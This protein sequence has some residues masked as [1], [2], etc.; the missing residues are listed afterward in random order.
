MGRRGIFLEHASCEELREGFRKVFFDIQSHTVNHKKLSTLSTQDLNYELS[1]DQLTLRKCIG[2]LERNKTVAIHVAY[3]FGADN[4]QVDRLAARYFLSGYLYND[5]IFR[6]GQNLKSK[7][8]GG[9]N[10]YKIP[11]L[12][13]DPLISVEKLKDMADGSARFESLFLKET[14]LELHLKAQ[15]RGTDSQH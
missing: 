4:E 14:E 11:C 1:E 8:G 6:L 12:T 3:P 7:L 9:I 5:A 13:I 10:R 2:D 15:D